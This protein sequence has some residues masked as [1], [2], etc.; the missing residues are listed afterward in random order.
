MYVPR[1]A[2]GDRVESCSTHA[3]QPI[4]P[5]ARMHPEVMEFPTEYPFRFAI[6]VELAIQPSFQNFVSIARAAVVDGVVR[7]SV[8]IG[9]SQCIGIACGEEQ[10]CPRR[11]YDDQKQSECSH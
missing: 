1:D 4:V 9:V 5:L 3:S 2:G 6:Q 8:D 10:T 11:C 7:S